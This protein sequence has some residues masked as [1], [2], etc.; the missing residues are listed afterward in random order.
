[1]PLLLEVVV[2]VQESVAAQA[3]ES[4]AAQAAESVAA[5]VVVLALDQH[6]VQVQV[7]AAEYPP[8]Y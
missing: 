1:M 5:L 7:Q 6:M 3:A 4:V 2:P 8:V